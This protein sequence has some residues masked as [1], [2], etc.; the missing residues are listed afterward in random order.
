MSQR[1][2]SPNLLTRCYGLLT[3]TKACQSHINGVVT[4]TMFVI[5]AKAKNFKQNIEYIM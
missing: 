5:G 3:A 2:N 4:A 1:P